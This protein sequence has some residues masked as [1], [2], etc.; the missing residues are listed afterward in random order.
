MRAD[1]CR[2]G[3]FTLKLPEA[4]LRAHSLRVKL[5]Q[6][7]INKIRS[8][9]KHMYF[10]YV[11]YLTMDLYFIN[12]SKRKGYTS[13]KPSIAFFINNDE[14]HRLKRKMR[15]T[16]VINRIFYNYALCNFLNVLA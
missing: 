8:G 2:Y 7:L 12:T 4:K 10:L 14:L 9:L 5:C 1:G 11:S 16:I 15:Q 13:E 3:L 6:A